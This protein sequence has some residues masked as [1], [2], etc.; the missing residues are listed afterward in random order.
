[1]FLSAYLALGQTDPKKTSQ[2]Q[3]T[4]KKETPL[5]DKESKKYQRLPFRGKITKIDPKTKTIV[6]KGK[7]V[8]RFFKILKETKIIKDG[9]PSKFEVAKVG[10]EV[11][12]YAQ[13]TAKKN[14]YDLISLRIGPKPTKKPPV[15]EK[16]KETPKQE[17]GPA[18]NQKTQTS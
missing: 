4:E 12:G 1:M 7:T 13:K 2:S 3:K 14:Y 17:R 8:T 16:P 6:L 5:A 15:A 11:G 9:K 10:N 18:T